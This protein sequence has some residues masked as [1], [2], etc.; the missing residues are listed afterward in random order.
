MRINDFD[1]NMVYSVQSLNEKARKKP[2]RKGIVY[3]KRQL[4]AQ[5]IRCG[6]L[7]VNEW[8]KSFVN[9]YDLRMFGDCLC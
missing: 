6:C 9:C 8:I 3:R 2:S 4:E 7:K 1:A 5:A